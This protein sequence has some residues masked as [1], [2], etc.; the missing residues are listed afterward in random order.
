MP[1]RDASDRALRFAVLGD[2]EP[3]PAP[4]FVN[5]REA[6]DTI[7]EMHAVDPFDFVGGI[8]DLVHQAKPEQYDIATDLLADLEPVFH[9]ILG[10]EELSGTLMQFFEHAR[11]WNDAPGQIP[12]VRYVNQY[13]GYRCIYATAMWEGIHFSE[14]EIDWIV[15]QIDGDD[16]PAILFVHNSPRGVFPDARAELDAHFD[17]V[18]E[19]PNAVLVFSGHSHMNP[20][21]VRT[22]G[23]DDRDSYH[24]HVPGIER[25]K[26]GETHVPRFPV[27]EI[28]SG[29]GTTAALYNLDREAFERKHTLALDIAPPATDAT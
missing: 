10:N 6:V 1:Q 2:A 18:L 25:T 21:N 8:G 29:G 11:H 22:H 20:D 27:V 26:V 28:G 12:D 14:A 9:P 7:N 16:R 19:Q 24:V 5:L 15:D 4:S 3:K 17:R 13:G 23:R